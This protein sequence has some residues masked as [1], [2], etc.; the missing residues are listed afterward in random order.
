MTLSTGLHGIR[1]VAALELKQR[2]RTSRWPVVLGAWVGVI[3]LVTFL[4]G[5][6]GRST[7]T[8]GAPRSTTC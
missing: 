3:G 2:R 4:T 1:T 5:R 7:P 6:A 8:M